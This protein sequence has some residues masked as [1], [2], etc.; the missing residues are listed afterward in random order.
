MR[1]L[2]AA[3]VVLAGAILSGAGVAAIAIGTLSGPQG[4][5]DSE[6]AG[7]LAA[8]VGAFVGFVGLVMVVV[9]WPQARQ[10]PD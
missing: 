1:I 3:I 8:L 6:I 7:G 10:R 5:M 2:A 4:R 9:D